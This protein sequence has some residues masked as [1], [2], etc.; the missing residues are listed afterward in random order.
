MDKQAFKQRMQA[1]KS[2][3][4][5]N[6][7]KG[8]LD[9]KQYADGGEV[10]PEQQLGSYDE[11]LGKRIITNRLTTNFT[12][13][14][15]W[16]ANFA[17]E[18]AKRPE[19]AD[20]L[21]S[22]QLTKYL[23]RVYNSPVRTV[24]EGRTLPANAAGITRYDMDQ[25][26]PYD[27]KD[28][29]NTRAAVTVAEDP[30]YGGS[31]NNPYSQDLNSNVVHELDHTTQMST[32]HGALKRTGYSKRVQKVADIMGT[33]LDKE[34]GMYGAQPW[35]VLS[36]R[37]QMFHEMNADPNKKYEKQDIKSIK[38]YLKKYDLDFL[39]DDKVMQ[40][41]NDV[42]DNSMQ[43][44]NSIIEN[45]V[46]HGAEGGEI[47]PV[48]KPIIPKKPEK[49]KGKLYKD[50]YGK[51][52]TEDQVAE[53]YDSS[54][55]EIDRFT[56]SPMVR[57]L[58]PVG[59]IED[60]A[61]V[62]PVGDAISV[63]DAYKSIKEGDWVG[64]GLS[65]LALLPFVPRTG[66]KL[67]KPMTVKEFRKH[68]KGV[69]PK[70]KFKTN[71]KSYDYNMTVNKNYAQDRIN[72]Y[73]RLDKQNLAKRTKA[74]NQSY[75]IAERLMDD[76][77]YMTRA[78]E[79]KKQF[80]DDYVRPYSDI[81]Q[82]YNTDPSKLPNVSA[83]K[84][85]GKVGSMVNNSGNYN[86]RLDPQMTNLDEFLTEHEYGHYVDFKRNKDRLS[87]E[88]DSN[89][90]YQMSKDLSSKPID[91]SG[92]YLKPTEQKSHMNQLRE[93][94]FQ[95][96]LINRRGQKVSEKMLEKALNEVSNVP[97]LRGVAKASKQFKN[98]SKYTKWF[99]SIPLLG[100]GAAAVYNT[101][102]E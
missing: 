60:A 36:R 96:G 27:S 64:A 84:L 58:K 19:F 55:D 5:Q 99:N 85:N 7:G 53:Y 32:T 65:T 8:Y 45:K 71:A 34:P 82:Y 51:K 12:E 48:D 13:E 90:F 22:D 3:R 69:T 47:P 75:N 25:N 24:S 2:Y 20:Q 89:M 62:T 83:E 16:L 21:D 50:K 76:P 30:T 98:M 63:Y 54:T 44:T 78:I 9:F 35:E 17:K 14:R 101:K 91:S 70:T 81:I 42:A 80:G 68:Y 102:E 40:L 38:G 59:D 87:A 52:Y 77:D 61:N 1:L 6:P 11:N 100:V 74:V 46:F 31:N 95:N 79:V 56:G 4:E 66:S 57:G 49:Y 39:G 15:D 97:S 18:R 93:Y 67:V 86:Y 92:Y 28:F 23:N 10:P 43:N 72:E 88:G 37:Q 73:D 94:M 41:L 33:N 29:Y 26:I